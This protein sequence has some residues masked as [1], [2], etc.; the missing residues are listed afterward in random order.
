MVETHP[1]ARREAL[2][3]LSLAPKSRNERLPEWFLPYRL[4]FCAY[5]A[6][7]Y[8]IGVG[9]PL[10]S[11][12]T[13][14]QTHRY[15][16]VWQCVVVTKR[17]EGI[18]GFY[19]GLIAPLLSSSAVRAVSV[20]MFNFALPYTSSLMFSIYSPTREKASSWELIGRK[21]PVAFLAGMFAGVSCTPVA[22]PFEYTKLASQI[23]LLVRP[24]GTGMVPQSTHQVAKNL[25]RN[26]GFRSLYSGWKLHCTRDMMGSA[27]YFTVYESVKAGLCSLLTPG[28]QQGN[29]SKGS[30]STA[31][32]VAGAMAGSVS[33]LVIYPVDTYKS[34][35]QRDMYAKSMGLSI[36]QLQGRSVEEVRRR[37]IFGMYSRKM[38][39]GLTV[40]LLRTS[41]MG[42]MFFSSYEWLIKHV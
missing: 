1:T 29:A 39:R 37:G 5:L 9:F 32:A 17:N 42:M 27:V 18:R 26:S 31:I 20:S 3:E 25:I 13:R 15:K 8:A 41:V 33:W 6:S 36:S 23:D 34:M 11:I 7:I 4:P 14:Q 22:C 38:Y 40:S 30:K 12:K 19:R 24:P 21:M 35:V 28:G 16:S 10:D 2:N